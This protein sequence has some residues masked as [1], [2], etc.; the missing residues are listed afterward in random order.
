MIVVA[1]LWPKNLLFSRTTEGQKNHYIFYTRD[2]TVA[3][4]DYYNE[5]KIIL[6]PMKRDDEKTFGYFFP[7]KLKRKIKERQKRVARKTLGR[8]KEQ[9]IFR[10]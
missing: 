8:K 6:H 3:E 9:N 10:I 1:F 4:E 2:N 7:S 5:D